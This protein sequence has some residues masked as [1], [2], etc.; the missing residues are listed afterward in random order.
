MPK[1]DEKPKAMPAAKSA[2][3]EARVNALE[4]EVEAL[5]LQTAKQQNL[6]WLRRVAGSF[7]GDAG[8]LE[9]ASLGAEYRRRQPKC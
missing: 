4:V 2:E 9:A 3:L 8:H 5:K 7:E 6:A 1:V